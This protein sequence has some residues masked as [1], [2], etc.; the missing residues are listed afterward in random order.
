MLPTL[1]LVDVG[2][3][4]A[5][6]VVSSMAIWACASSILTIVFLPKVYNVTTGAH[7]NLT[8]TNSVRHIRTPGDIAGGFKTIDKNK[9]STTPTQSTG[10]NADS[11]R[12]PTESGA[13]AQHGLFFEPK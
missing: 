4:D 2:K 1:D 12:K 5:A 10:K 9:T 7:S 13:P 3:P 8:A 11:T 6:L